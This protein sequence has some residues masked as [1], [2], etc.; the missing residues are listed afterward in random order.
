MRVKLNGGEDSQAVKSH[1][2]EM[3]RCDAKCRV[4][5]FTKSVFVSL[6]FY[7]VKDKTQSGWVDRRMD[8]SMDGEVGKM[9]T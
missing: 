3:K 4:F 1:L 7:Q 6:N 5:A 9:M 2:Q 8:G